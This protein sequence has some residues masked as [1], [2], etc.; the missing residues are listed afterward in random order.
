[1]RKIL[2]YFIFLLVP[3]LSGAQVFFTEDFSDGNVTENPVWL[4]DTSKF[5]VN[6]DT[7]LQLSNSPI[8][9]KAV[10]YTKVALQDSAD[11][12]FYFRLDFSPSSSNYLK[13]FLAGNG[14]P[15]S[16][17]FEGFFLRVGEAGN[18]D[19]LELY[20]T[21]NGQE[22]LVLRG[23]DSL[24]ARALATWIH[25]AVKNGEWLLEIDTSGDGNYLFQ[26]KGNGY[27]LPITT[28]FG[29][30]C[31]H[32][33][34]RSDKFYFD[35]FRIGPLY[36]DHEAPYISDLQVLSD[37][38]LQLTFN[39]E[40]DSS[41]ASTIGNYSLTGKGQP[42]IQKVG[43]DSQEHQIWKLY[44]NPALVNREAYQLRAWSIRD[45]NGNQ[46]D[47][48][49]IDFVH[50]FPAYHDIVINEIFPDPSPPRQ[51]PEAEFIE[52]YNATEL[53]ISLNDFV[54]SDATASTRFAN[55]SIEAGEYLI[56]C[57]IA[58][59]ALFSKYGRVYGMQGFPSLNNSGDDLSLYTSRGDLLDRVSYNSSWYQE[60]D[61][62]D[63]GWTL[64]RIEVDPLC[65]GK[66]NWHAST[67]LRG[68]TP[69]SIN[70]VAGM[71][72]DSSAPVLLSADI[73]SP[74]AVKLIWNER[75]A[76]LPGHVSPNGAP[77]IDSM[78]SGLQNGI[79]FLL[80]H[81][82]DS[83]QRGVLYTILLDSLSDCAGNQ[84]SV[85]AG[86]I[87]AFP[88]ERNDLVI[89]EILF[90][91]R[92]GGVDYVEI[93]NRSQ[94]IIA[95]AGLQ[96][97]ERDPS[98]MMLSDMASAAQ[99]FVFLMPDD[100][101]VFT[102]DTQEVAS[103]YFVKYPRKM[104]Q[105]PG[106]PNYPDDEGV[107]LLRDSSGMTIDSVHYFEDWHY[108]LLADRNGVSLERID[109]EGPANDPVNWFS[110]SSLRGYGTPTDSNSQLYAPPSFQGSIDVSP[111][112]FSPDLD[113]YKDLLT[114]R[115]QTE[116]P[117]YSCRIRIFDSRG[118]PVR[119]LCDNELL[120]AESEFRWDGLDDELQ[121]LREGIYIID[122]ELLHPE[123]ILIHEKRKC[124][125]TYR[126]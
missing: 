108:E 59:T 104:I 112:V 8:T 118:Y 58:D 110:A 1:M 4:G 17:Q 117:G 77:A 65:T 37:T 15:G 102:S 53:S 26:G 106:M 69:G 39:E 30:E 48:Q 36:E 93:L 34:S 85:D 45:L 11:W 51:L 95:M 82:A 84:G 78:E 29:L 42:L 81:F 99:K 111:E 64:E 27:P 91:P 105:L 7:Q 89:N 46:M 49:I 56:L 35:D 107:V 79:P 61:K 28:F 25:V 12:Y 57:D 119:T 125:L 38:V 70:S 14:I 92:S 41:S 71:R 73:V 60:E 76:G 18:A 123:G 24:A 47:T 54:L 32:T 16:T 96:I 13:V 43:R 68:G 2:S 100:I 124:V 87:D 90:N 86:F 116:I 122:F 52:I 120:S 80:I 94:K 9:D 3:L 103:R 40:P 44:L 115:I 75:L 21:L 22:E 66:S 74:Y 121:K 63:G 72:W 50:F 33:A 113:G 23:T 6:A 55:T 109:P 97:A 67:D 62:R 20:R 101:Y 19:A 98:A 126:K 88:L 10:I 83:L 31:T 5:R 114:I